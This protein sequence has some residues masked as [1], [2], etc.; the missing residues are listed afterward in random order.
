MPC[1]DYYDDHPERFF[2]DVTEPALNKLV[3]FD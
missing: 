2:K 1:R 3:A